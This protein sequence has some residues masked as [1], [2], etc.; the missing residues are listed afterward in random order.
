MKYIYIFYAI[1]IF[2]SQ[3]LV[4]MESPDSNMVFVKN[5]ENVRSLMG[6]IIAFVS[7]DPN[8]VNM[9]CFTSCV[10]NNA[11][12]KYGYISENT[13]FLGDGQLVYYLLPIAEKGTQGF[14]MA[15]CD[16]YLGRTNLTIRC[17]SN[18]EIILL[19]N[20][21]KNNKDD[22][23]TLIEITEAL[24]LLEKQSGFELQKKKSI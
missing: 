6:K 19:H 4:S 18:E 1:L 7:N 24:Q 22:F 2:S 11:Q 21:I 13:A 3:L 5:G 16:S 8:V 17:A 14:C 23:M 9:Q 20:H 12:L 15:L 10:L